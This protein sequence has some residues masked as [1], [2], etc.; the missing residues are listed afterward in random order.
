MFRLPAGVDPSLAASANCALSQVIHGLDVV[1]L[2]S[3]ETVVVQG[4]GGLGLYACA[5]ARSRGAGRIIAIDGV[6]ARLEMARAFGADDVIDISAVTDRRAR[7]SQVMD[8]TDNWGADVVVE[9]VGIPD[10]VNEGIRML[11]R[12]GRYL[13]MGNIN[14]KQ[15]YKADPSLL[16]GANKSIVGVSLYPPPVLPRA[17]GFLERNATRFPFHKLLSHDY[18]LTDINRAFEEA[19]VFAKSQGSVIRASIVPGGCA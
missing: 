13:E 9:L 11:A 17:I 10:V 2:Q 5:V 19:D 15:T 16:V 3:G 6:P 1:N 12:G 7:V 4:A 8:L 14:P 18:A